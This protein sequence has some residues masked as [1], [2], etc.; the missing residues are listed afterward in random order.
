MKWMLIV[1][2]EVI[3]IDF[4]EDKIKVDE[5][6]AINGKGKALEAIQAARH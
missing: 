6:N 1:L 2:L 5:Y 3:K 4:S